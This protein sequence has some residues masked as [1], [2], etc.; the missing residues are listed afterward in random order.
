MQ[1]RQS[2]LAGDT[3][4][5]IETRNGER[6]QTSYGCATGKT[7]AN[8]TCVGVETREVAPEV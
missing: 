3:G 2:S 4:G 1:I 6:K 7:P 8:E 5:I